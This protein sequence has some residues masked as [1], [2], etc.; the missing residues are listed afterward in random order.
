MKKLKEEEKQ[1]DFLKFS[2]QNK[3]SQPENLKPQ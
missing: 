3:L 2:N 1:N